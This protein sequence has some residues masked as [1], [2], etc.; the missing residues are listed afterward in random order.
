MLSHAL[1]ALVLVAGL[2]FITGSVRADSHNVEAVGLRVGS[3]VTA[4]RLLHE[5]LEP[6]AH[7][8]E[9]HTAGL[10]AR[11][12]LRLRFDWIRSYTALGPHL[13]LASSAHCSLQPTRG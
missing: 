3:A 6:A 5:R 11:L 4:P 8:S 1:R 9:T 12:K 7:S 2:W 13:F 10:R